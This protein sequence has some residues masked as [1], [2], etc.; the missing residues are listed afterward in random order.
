MR[1]QPSAQDHVPSLDL[2]ICD[3]D[4][5]VL[6]HVTVRDLS[7]ALGEFPVGRHRDRRT[8]ARRRH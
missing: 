6:E 4:G 3:E 8:H 5:Q 1:S 7:T 2:E